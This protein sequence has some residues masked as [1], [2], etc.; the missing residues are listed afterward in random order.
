MSLRHVLFLTLSSTVL[1][2]V[3]CSVLD[4]SLIAGGEDSG[5]DS[6]TGEDSGPG[7]DAGNG[8]DGCDDGSRRPPPR[9]TIEDS[10]GP[11]V[12][13]ALKE[14]RLIQMGEAWREI[15]FNLDRLCSEA[16]AP[17]VEC[18]P[19]A[20]P[21][22]SPLID[23]NQG[24]DNAFGGQLTPLIDIVFPDLADSAVSA[25]EEGI[26]VV[27]TRIRGWNGEANDPRVD[28]TVT[29]S[30]DSTRGAAGDSAPTAEFRDFRAMMP[31]T[32][33][34][35]AEPVWDGN[36][37]VWAR[38]ETFFLGDPEQPR[39]RDDNAYIANNELVVTLP[40]RV[41]IVF[42][43]TAAG[44]LVRLSDA[45][46]VGRISDDRTRMTPA[47]FAGRWS[48]LDLLDTANT[49]GVCEGDTEFD[50]L[51]NQLNTIA[52]VRSVAGTGGEGVSCDA[53]SLGV[54]FEGYRVRI[55]GLT[56]GQI[57]PDG[58]SDE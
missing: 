5:V 6:A 44:L 40:D 8:M 41:E 12:I 26:G 34:D 49:V 23:G 20:F 14:V 22:A 55:A 50:L 48:I 2:L 15:G 54:T 51:R 52:D 11:E 58:C 39:V 30:V 7:I 9:P 4:P 21:D 33:T 10:D 25:A 45:L 47:T 37:W 42:A 36:D 17:L 28:V 31:G 35:L 56:P 43:N 16:P 57:P 18:L 32:D 24:I 53:I 46:A 19:P 3:G 1:T 38:E 27:I 29:Q 13:F